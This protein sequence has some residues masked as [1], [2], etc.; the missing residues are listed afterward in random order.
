MTEALANPIVSSGAWDGSPES[1]CLEVGESAIRCGL[2]PG[3]HMDLGEAALMAKGK[4]WRIPTKSYQLLHFYL[5]EEWVT[6]VLRGLPVVHHCLRST[7]SEIEEL[8]LRLTNDYMATAVDLHKYQIKLKH[9]MLLFLSLLFLPY[10][11]LTLW[12][13]WTSTPSAKLCLFTWIL[14]AI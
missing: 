1:P 6:S 10:L 13:I 7:A 8:S 14:G 3:G 4:S 9:L 11:C 5:L 2:S 12:K